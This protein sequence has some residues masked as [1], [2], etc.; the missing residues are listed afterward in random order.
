MYIHFLKKKNNFIGLETSQKHNLGR[1]MNLD[2]ASKNI[3]IHDPNVKLYLGQSNMRV[4]KERG[5]ERIS[6]HH[7]NPWKANANVIDP[8][9]R[10]NTPKKNKTTQI[11]T[12]TLRTRVT[13][14]KIDYSKKDKNLPQSTMDDPE[15][16]FLRTSQPQTYEPTM[17]S[18]RMKYTPQ[19][20]RLYSGKSRERIQNNEYLLN[21]HGGNKN[22]NRICR[23]N[24]NYNNNTMRDRQAKSQRLF[25]TQATNNAKSATNFHN[26][27]TY[28]LRKNEVR[29]ITREKPNATSQNLK[30][31]TE[32]VN[33][34]IRNKNSQDPKLKAEYPK[35]VNLSQFFFF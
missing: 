11:N 30:K 8:K 16:Q 20:N 6:F 22:S 23:D 7:N 32:V 13:G 25:N 28:H 17:S 27:Q 9:T 26:N 19:K 3:L 1:N 35:I 10:S 34:K 2:A 5:I 33:K 24:N 12:S 29:I 21:Q 18:F 31:T 15:T 14:A 4:A